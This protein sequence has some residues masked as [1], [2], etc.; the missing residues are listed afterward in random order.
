MSSGVL[1]ITTANTALADYID[2]SVAVV[3]GEKT[4]PS[5]VQG[6]AGDVAGR[7]YPLSFASRFDIARAIRDALSLPP[8]ERE[9][10][11][12]A[13][14]RRVVE[15]FSEGRVVELMR[16]SAPHLFEPGA[17]EVEGS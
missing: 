3:V 17:G 13:A 4:Y 10:K 12:D 2:E 9:R 16:Q 5:P 15:R 11:A 1:P 7:V 14:R 8:D 6:M